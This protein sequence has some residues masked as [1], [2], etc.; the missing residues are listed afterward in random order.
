[1]S[2]SETGS[3]SGAGRG[4]YG[5]L[6]AKGSFINT[7]QWFANKVATAVSMLVI[8]RFLVPEDYGVANQALAIAQFMI[9]FLPLTMGD[10]L[11]AHPRELESL[12][13]TARR[14]AL[15][16]GCGTTLVMLATIPLLV[17]VYDGYPALW[18]GGLIAVAALRP[19]LDALLM[20][21]L[22]RMRVALQYRR[23]ALID[24]LVQLGATGV[25]LVMAALGLRGA[26]LVAP[27]VGGAGFRA[28]LYRR[29]APTPTSGRFDG[30]LARMLLKAYVP[31]ASGQYLHNVIVMLEVLVLGYVAGDYQTGLFA[32][33][34]QVAAQAN[35]VVAYQLGVV[36]QPIFGHLRDDPDRQVAGFLRV[37]R[38]LGL[39]CVPISIAQVVVA[40]PLFRLAFPEKY[41]PAV[42]VFQVIS[43]AQAFYFATAP[44]M[45]CLR[46]QRR[47][48]TF[49]IWQGV[50]F[51]IS[52]P[53][54]AIGARSSGAVG[55][56]IASAALWAASAPVVV[57][58][59]T[60]PSSGHHL[61][62]VL[63]IFTKPWLI[64]VP[65]FAGAWLVSDRLAQFG[66]WGDLVSSL[67][68]VPLATILAVIASRWI[69]PEM[70]TLLDKA[71]SGVR[72]RFR[73]MRGRDARSTDGGSA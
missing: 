3:I 67:T 68:I 12:V 2:G 18:L 64:S 54:Y 33:A 28:M 53:V 37:Q 73:R 5:A 19:S 7:A 13:P 29:A 6:A 34:F 60:R 25:S 24:G 38:V 10:V 50:Q 23:I 46:S 4:S 31:A 47:F 17:R 15:A 44:S 52:V 72:D 39:V 41:A 27:Q 16:I 57:W 69:D 40:E 45:S 8:A 66:T 61:S 59:C 26:S 51:L 43:L 1:M 35:T 71:L 14:L 55:V 30:A 48:R 58:L 65:V 62:S 36:L 32:F 20:V 70:R 49:M 21:S 56:S 22:A 11:I 63:S 42:P 9:V